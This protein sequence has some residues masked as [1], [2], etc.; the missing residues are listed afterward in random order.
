M[1]RKGSIEGKLHQVESLP[2]PL[3]DLKS[4]VV[5]IN[6][7]FTEKVDQDL[8]SSSLL[9]IC[10][11]SPAE[12]RNKQRRLVG[13]LPS[14][15]PLERTRTPVVEGVKEVSKLVT[16]EEQVSSGSNLL[17]EVD[18]RDEV[19]GLV[20][21]IKSAALHKIRGEGEGGK[22]IALA[23]LQN[24]LA[25]LELEASTPLEE[26]GA[27]TACSTQNTNWR[28]TDSTKYN[29]LGP[30]EAQVAPVLPPRFE[31]QERE[32]L[33]K[34]GACAVKDTRLVEDDQAKGGVEVTP[35]ILHSG[36]GE[37]KVTVH[38]LRLEQGGK[39]WCSS[40]GRMVY[41]CKICHQKGATLYALQRHVESIHFPHT[42][43][44][45]CNF[46][47][48]ES[49]SKT[50]HDCHINRMHKSEK[51]DGITKKVKE[52][53]TPINKGELN[54]WSDLDQYVTKLPDDESG[55]KVYQ[56]TIC[57]FKCHRSENLK[58]HVECNHFRGALKHT[59]NLCETDF[60]TKYALLYHTTHKH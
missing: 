30:L 32:S 2:W 17:S 36:E 14:L 22:R 60:D 45:I 34:A 26:L 1:N 29:G 10:H 12:S 41:S 37:N 49:A 51:S 16:L 25:S 31:K 19:L 11:T 43:K 59:C 20:E 27:D 5:H 6:A 15:S 46:C 18:I 8:S 9:N 4:E 52:V 44:Y 40:K 55:L 35:C 58:K 23:A 56:C 42:F 3:L 48:K 21:Q 33:L 53:K 38:L 47:E 57:Q 13:N 24:C 50:A 7:L 54:S 39:S 28:D